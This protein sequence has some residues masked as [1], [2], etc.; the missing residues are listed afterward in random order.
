MI[1]CVKTAFLTSKADLE[2]LFACNRISAEIWNQ[3]LLIAKDYSLQHD[4]AWIGQTKLQA[5][6]KQQ[7][8]LHSQSVQAVCHKYLLARDSANKRNTKVCLPN[9]RTRTK[10]TSTRNG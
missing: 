3:C 2:R 8:P 9:T 7:F 5:A 4:G 10:H 6:L 1:R